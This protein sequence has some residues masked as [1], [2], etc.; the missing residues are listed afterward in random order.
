[1]LYT[2]L[3]I[4]C[5]SYLLPQTAYIDI[6]LSRLLCLSLVETGTLVML[7]RFYTVSSKVNSAMQM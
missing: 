5:L 3:Y 2:S 4:T 7:T 6:A 1:M